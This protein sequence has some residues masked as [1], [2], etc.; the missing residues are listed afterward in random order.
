MDLVA[1]VRYNGK[2]GE[3]IEKGIGLLG[4]WR[5]PKSPFIVKPTL[6]LW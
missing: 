5:K 2:I 4:G 6:P 3:T 1:L